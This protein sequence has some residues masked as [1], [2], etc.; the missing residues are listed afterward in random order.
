MLIIWSDKQLKNKYY[1]I[2]VG[3]LAKA[4]PKD[5]VHKAINA[6]I[7]N[8]MRSSVQRSS[9]P[10]RREENVNYIRHFFTAKIND[11]QRN[12]GHAHIVLSNRI[13][14]EML[15]NRRNV[16]IQNLEPNSYYTGHYQEVEFKKVD[17]T[18]AHGKLLEFQ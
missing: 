5:S 4:W 13:V 10:L 2:F 1:P 14:A 6:E 15:L 16:L 3:R 18:K 9:L 11:G 17:W 12:S 8:L 7:N